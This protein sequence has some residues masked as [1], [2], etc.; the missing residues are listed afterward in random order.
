MFIGTNYNTRK[1]P[2]NNKCTQ[3]PVVV[4]FG[5]NS[6]HIG[7]TCIGDP[8]FL[9][10]QNIMLPVFRK[11]GIGLSCIGIASGTGFGKAVGTQSI[12]R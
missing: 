7:K 9:T 5:K 6:L 8:H 1:I 2:F 10:I 11:P 4:N 3:N 12:H